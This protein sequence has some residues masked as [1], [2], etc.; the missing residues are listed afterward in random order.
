MLSNFEEIYADYNNGRDTFT[1]NNNGFLGEDKQDIYS[2]DSQNSFI[3]YNSLQQNNIL[4]INEFD[5]MTN[6]ENNH[7]E[8]SKEINKIHF[9]TKND[10]DVSENNLLNKKRNPIFNITKDTNQKK[11]MNK[12]NNVIPETTK[13]ET[14]KKGRKTKNYKGD[15]K[16]NKSSGDNIINKI[17]GYF[18]NHYLRDIIRK[19]SIYGNLEL[20]KLPNN[21][22]ADLKQCENLRLYKMKIKDILREQ[23]ISTKY[24]TYNDFENRIIIEDIYRK[25]KELK[26]IKILELTFEELLVIFRKKINYR[27]DKKLIEKIANKIG[28]LDLISNNDKYDD[29]SLLI[30]STKN[31]YKNMD[32]KELN[33]YINDIQFLCCNY[34]KWFNDKKVRI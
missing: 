29:I 16:H 17:K 5:N 22:I 23:S 11:N 24:K 25:S 18:I 15:T 34:I 28:E 9:I 33:E 21:F 2:F 32:E 10:N 12:C 30:E 6:G 1:D 31:K 3:F 27:D 4:F 7:S 19:N 8:D 20:K 26:V 14:K 13:E